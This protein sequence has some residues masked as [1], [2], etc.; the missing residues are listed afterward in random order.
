V[1]EW[2]VLGSVGR[3]LAAWPILGG[4]RAA[5]VTIVATAPLGALVAGGG[6]GRYVVDGLA[7]QDQARLLVGALLVA[8]GAIAAETAFGWL[9][10]VVAP[11][12]HWTSTPTG[13]AP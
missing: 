1:A 5:A 9:A 13:P 6:L 10:R 11:A 4:I 12:R 8:L 3:P 2:Q 7:S